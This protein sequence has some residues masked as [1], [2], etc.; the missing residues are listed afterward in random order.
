M[1]ATGPAAA[2]PAL[3]ATG[4]YLPEQIRTN[5]DPIFDW[6]RDNPQYGSQLFTG[7]DERR[8]LGPGETVTSIMVGAAR[9][10]LVQGGLGPLDIDLLTGYGS[11]GQYITP[12]TLAQVHAE[13]GMAP[14]TEVLP[15][16]NDFANWTSGVVLA[17]ALIR[18]GR[19]QRAL[20]VCGANWTQYV[21]YHTPQSVSA[22]DGA[23]ATVVAP[24]T[25]TTQWQL[26]DRQYLTAS[27]HYGD[28]FV[29]PDSL[30]AGSF[31]P[32]YMHITAAGMKDYVVFGEQQAA[33]LVQALLQRHNLTDIPVTMICHQSSMTLIEAWQTALPNLTIL[34]TIAQYANLEVATIPVNLDQ[35]GAQVTTDYLVTLAL[36]VQLNAG[37]LL[38][39]RGS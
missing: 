14:S 6:L 19:I 18:A 17:D 29:A 27:N 38:F 37:A 35:L 22:A 5:D 7:Y 1:S 25:A 24:A 11:V 23:G 34:Q 20:I 36:G 4:S 16:A 32:P 39:T 15:L 12:N 26:V 33:G 2:E 9:A 3:V 21:D 30:A 8:I 31:G 28:M 13:L 10:A